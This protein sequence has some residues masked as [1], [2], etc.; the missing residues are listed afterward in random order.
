MKLL[1]F[2]KDLYTIPRSLTGKGVVKTLEYISE[3][4]PLEIKNIKS[5]SKVFDWQVPP[6]W[7]VKKAYILDLNSGKR[8]VDLENH[9][10][11][12]LG[13]SKPVDEILSYRDLIKNIFYIKDQPTAIPYVTSYYSE[14]WGFCMT[15]EDFKRLD[16]DSK[17][18]VYIDSDLNQEGSLHYAELVIKGKVDKEI[19]ISSYICHPQTKRNGK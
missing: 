15:Y 3:I 7:N 16:K 14:R 13:Y 8:V 2:C 19:F 6:E 9:G 17:F 5:G 4:V 10:L 18:Q 11:H 1:D 12:I